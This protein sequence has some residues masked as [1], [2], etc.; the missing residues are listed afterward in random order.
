M[1]AV[2]VIAVVGVVVLAAYRH[3]PAT[4]TAYDTPSVGTGVGPWINADSTTCF[5]DITVTTG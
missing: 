5:E 2:L 1:A 3:G 4:T